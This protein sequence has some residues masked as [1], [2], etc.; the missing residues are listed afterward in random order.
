[1]AEKRRNETRQ[2]KAAMESQAVKTELEACTL[3]FSLSA[4]RF[5]VGFPRSMI[6]DVVGRQFL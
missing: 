5:A 6:G 1:M 4:I 2:L 3:E